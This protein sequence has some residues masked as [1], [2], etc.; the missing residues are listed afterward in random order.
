MPVFFQQQISEFSRMGV[1][2]IEEGEEF[3]KG[4]VPYH[5]QVTH[6]HKRLQHLAGR[7]L[8]QYLF[9]DFPHE[10]I[11]IAD[12]RKPYLKDEQFHFSISHCGDYAAA[13]VSRKQRVGVDVE[14]QVKKI[15]R[16]KER[17]LGE[18]EMQQWQHRFIAGDTFLPTLLWSA[19]EAV[20]K[21]YGNGCVDFRKDIRITQ[22]NEKQETVECF[23]GKTHQQIPIHYRRFGLLILSWVEMNAG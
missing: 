22:W 6:P 16:L 12:T 8:L 14:L 11:R 20:F 21:W 7:F 9:P 2:K 15:Y 3:F 4:H 1:W 18:T 10:L 23:F 17:F 19:K 13:I 5:R